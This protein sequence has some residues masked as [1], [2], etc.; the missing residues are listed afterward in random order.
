[1]LELEKLDATVEHHPLA[2]DEIIQKGQIV[3]DLEKN[4]FLEEISWRQKSQALWLREGDKNTKI[5]HCL[6]NSNR[7]HNSISTLLING[8]LSLEPKAI[9]KC[10]T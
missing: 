8:E 4:A 1:M 6:A 9:S 3:A 7:R 10:I 2:E 5:F